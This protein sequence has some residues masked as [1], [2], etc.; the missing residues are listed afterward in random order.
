ME[1]DPGDVE[2]TDRYTH[3]PNE[4]VCPRSVEGRWVVRQPAVTQHLGD[5]FVALGGSL[6]RSIQISVSLPIAAKSRPHM[7]STRPETDDG[8]SVRPRRAST[9]KALLAHCSSLRIGRPLGGRCKGC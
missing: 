6:P 8:V 2:Q 3:Q 9:P 5:L 1:V 4:R 7:N